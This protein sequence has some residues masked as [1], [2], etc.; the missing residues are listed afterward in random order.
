MWSCHRS[1]GWHVQSAVG[2]R[3]PWGCAKDYLGGCYQRLFRNLQSGCTAVSAFLCT[4]QWCFPGWISGLC[5]SSFS[6]IWCSFLS[7][8]STPS[9]I[10]WMMILAGYC[11]A[12]TIGW[13]LSRC[14]SCSGLLSSRSSWWCLLSSLL[15]AVSPEYKITKKQMQFL[16]FFYFNDDF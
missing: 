3:M 8:W 16:K 4:A 1:S 14:C 15:V 2:S 5:T 6:K 9:E 10:C 12:L 13:Y 11:L 7:R